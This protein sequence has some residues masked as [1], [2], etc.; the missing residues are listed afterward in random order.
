MKVTA[1]PVA[2]VLLIEPR[3]FPD[4]RGFLVES[5]Q[6][7][8]YAQHGI[9]ADFVQDNLSR[10]GRGVLRGLHFQHPQ[11]QGKLVSIAEGRVLDV[12]VDVRPASPTFGKVAVVELSGDNQHQ[13][14]IPPGCAHGF[15]V[16]SDVALCSYKCTDFY[17]PAKERGVRFD[18]PD[19]AIP[20]P[21][22]DFIVS[23]KDRALPLLKDIPRSELP[24]FS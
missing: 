1:L 2:G 6:Q 15:C 19:L 22:M 17:A 12:A 8:R 23:E 3:V 16:L 20:W 10:S 21:T 5:W 11:G 9:T 24:P 4:G 18:D 14:Y 7:H 13:L